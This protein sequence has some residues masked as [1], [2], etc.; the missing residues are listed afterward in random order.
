[1]ARAKSV[2]ASKRDNDSD[3][4][5]IARPLAGMVVEASPS[6]FIHCIDILEYLSSMKV[7]GSTCS[8]SR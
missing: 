3:S 5:G 8:C 7:M 4:S 6:A 1:M 2:R